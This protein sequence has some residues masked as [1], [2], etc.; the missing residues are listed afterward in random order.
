LNKPVEVPALGHAEVTHEGKEPTYTEKGY[1]TYHSCSRCDWC[2]EIVYIPVLG[3]TSSEGMD[4]VF[5][6]KEYTSTGICVSLE[7]TAEN[8]LSG[9]VVLAAYDSTGKLIS[10]RFVSAEIAA[11]AS[12]DFTVTFPEGADVAKIKGFVLGTGCAPEQAVW[13]KRF[14]EDVIYA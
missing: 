9:T 7:N 11:K 14:Y 10:V 1:E 6:Y 4:Y 5:S 8:D 13:E 12:Q 2:E 3:E